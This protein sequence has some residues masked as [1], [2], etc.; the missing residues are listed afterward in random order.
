VL[1]SLAIGMLL[2]L[3]SKNE[4]LVAL[5]VPVPDKKSVSYIDKIFLEIAPATPA[6]AENALAANILYSY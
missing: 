2:V 3:L 6:A 1:P 4:L 5:F